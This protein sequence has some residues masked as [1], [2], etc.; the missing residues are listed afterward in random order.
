MADDT[1]VWTPGSFTKNFSWGNGQGLKQL[2]DVIRIGFDG[3]VVDTPRDVFRQRV[4]D[5]PLPD[6]VPINFF[7]FNTIRG[8][9]SLLI[10][11]E[12]VFQAISFS[13][14][15]RFDHLALFALFFSHA[16]HWKSAQRY[17]D[18]PAL[19]ALHYIAD[20]IGAGWMWDTDI[21]NADDIERFVIGDKRY[22]GQGAR[23]LATNLNY[24]LQA[25]GIDSYPSKKV[26]RWWVDAIFLALDRLVELRLFENR[27]VSKSK[28]EIYLATSPFW[29]ISGPSSLEKKL[30]AKH[31]VAL[32][33]V[34]GGRDRFDD[35]AVREIERSLLHHL[36]NWLDDDSV[37]IAAVH[38]TNPKIIKTIPRVCAMLAKTVGFETF[39]VD[40]L[41]ELDLPELIKGNLEKALSLLKEHDVSPIMTTDQLMKLMRGE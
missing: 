2:H 25:G 8:G 34:C 15:E 9:E 28:Y 37:P 10:A 41:A 22:T 11:D 36:A 14:T 29:E 38:R 1:E 16:G 35:L 32:F 13:H 18:R 5:L 31:V 17:Q 7:L 21:I 3:K 24:I 40:E 33:D 6:Y 39:D 26:V 23:K 4:K 27:P 20:R 19:W 12:L 30:A